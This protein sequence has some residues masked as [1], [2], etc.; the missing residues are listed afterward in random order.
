MLVL[1]EEVSDS[2]SVHED[3]R[4]VTDAV[5]EWKQ[6]YEKLEIHEL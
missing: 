6:K 5:E 2:K 1:S 3:L 4:E